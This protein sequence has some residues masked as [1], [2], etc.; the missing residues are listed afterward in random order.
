MNRVKLFLLTAI[1]IATAFT[2]GSCAA[3]PAQ[4][5]QLNA[6]PQPEPQKEEK[7]AEVIQQEQQQKADL[8]SVC[9]QIR[10]EGIDCIV[11]VGESSLE[12]PARDQSLFNARY[13][14]AQAMQASVKSETEQTTNIVDRDVQ[15]NYTQKAT[16]TAEQ[17]VSRAF[18]YATRTAFDGTYY[19]VYTLMVI[20]PE[21]VKGIVE[22]SAAATGNE[23]V[24]AKVKSP[25]VQDR[26]S[27]KIAVFKDVV[28]PL[29]KKI[30][31]N[32]IR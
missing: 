5:A 2:I 19:K 11:G 27:K 14:Y 4:Q 20:N 15:L 8:E 32:I 26:F 1:S 29:L 22:A 13:L 12:G 24:A 30:A 18:P 17:T 28:L 7:P 6:S 21:D 3:T 23:A 10:I 25:E 9:S 16:E 31:V